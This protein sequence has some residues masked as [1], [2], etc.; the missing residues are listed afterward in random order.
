MKEGQTVSTGRGEEKRKTNG[1]GEEGMSPSRSVSFG[2]FLFTEPSD[3]N[4]SILCLFFPYMSLPV[5]RTGPKDVRP[6]CS[7]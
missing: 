1:E 5:G 4:I 2:L 6:F 7:C 3:D